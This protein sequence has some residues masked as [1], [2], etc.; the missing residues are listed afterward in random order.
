MCC[1]PPNGLAGSDREIKN[2]VANDF[3]ELSDSESSVYRLGETPSELRDP[4]RS[5]WKTPDYPEQ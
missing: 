4:T 2:P 5:P 1:D 3:A